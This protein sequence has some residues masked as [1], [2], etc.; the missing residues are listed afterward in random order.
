VA[1]D[2]PKRHLDEN[3]DAFLILTIIPMKIGMPCRDLIFYL[4][5]IAGIS[6][7]RA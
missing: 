7:A 6:H 1:I 3:R 2:D 4:R 5:K